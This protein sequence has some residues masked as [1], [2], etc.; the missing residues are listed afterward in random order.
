MKVDIS[1]VNVGSTKSHNRDKFN[2]RRLSKGYNI[3]SLE[4]K[5]A[6]QN[7]CNYFSIGARVTLFGMNNLEFNGKVSVIKSLLEPSS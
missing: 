2:R 7:E 3:P 5:D 4:M 1:P 6:T